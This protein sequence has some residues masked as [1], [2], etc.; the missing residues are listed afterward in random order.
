MQI[1]KRQTA[2]RWH[3]EG[4]EE[5]GRWLLGRL[6]AV[7]IATGPD[8]AEVEDARWLQAR[9]GLGA[10]AT[11]GKAD[12][13]QTAGLL[14]RARLYVGTDTAAMHLAAAC[15]CPAVAL[16]GS[17]WEG[18]W[19][20][21]RSDYRIVTETASAP[22]GNP[23]DDLARAKQRSMAGIAPAKVIAACEEMLVRTAPLPGRSS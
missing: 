22:S 8:P 16:F 20:P 21:W 6:G 17:T 9:L 19:H 14:C 11:E 1:G 12:W 18:H 5:V 15:G 3:R 7:V 4:W 10:L 13:P 23:K 2:G